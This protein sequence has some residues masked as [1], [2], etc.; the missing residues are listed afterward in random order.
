MYAIIKTGG[1]QYKVS[2]GTTV[3]VERLDA[4]EGGKYDFNEVLMIVDGESVNVGTPFLEGLA[5]SADIK[6]H[7]RA[8]KVEIIKFKRRKHHRKQMGHRQSYTE[9]EIT[10]I[11]GK[12]AKPAAKKAAPKA[13]PAAKAAPAKKAAAP[14]AAPAAKTGDTFLSAPQGT[15][16]DLKKISGVGPV[17][18]K[19]LNALGIYHFWQVAQFTAEDIADVDD[20]L[21]FKG[22]IERDDWLTQAKQFA[23]EVK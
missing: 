16:D 10:S 22:R 13:K 17:L 3:R 21:S 18:E 19:K 8:K 6:A 15:A 14:K 11:G 1:K 12:A 23:E 7:G 5:V 2:Q 9:V 4:E 20:K